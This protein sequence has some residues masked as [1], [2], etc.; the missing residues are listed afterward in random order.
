MQFLDLLDFE[1]IYFSTEN[2]S[3]RINPEAVTIDTNLA[4]KQEEADTKVVLHSKH[5]LERSPDKIVIVR[6]SSADIDINILMLSLFTDCPEKLYFDVGNGKHR[7][8]FYLDKIELEPA[9]KRVL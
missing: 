3:L 1:E 6:S 2:T 8:G 9:V 7:K 4:S 5:A